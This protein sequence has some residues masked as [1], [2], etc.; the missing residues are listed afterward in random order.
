MIASSLISASISILQHPP[1][2]PL[3]LFN[4]QLHVFVF[5]VKFP[6]AAYTC[7]DIVYKI[8]VLVLWK[9]MYWV[10]TNNGSLMV[11]LF[12]VGV[13]VMGV[14]IFILFHI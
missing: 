14:F 9:F 13:M 4:S 5:P 3:N 7:M 10:R 8:K 6:C 12:S 1:P 2:Y 11:L